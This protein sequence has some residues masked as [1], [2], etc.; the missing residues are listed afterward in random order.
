MEAGLLALE[1]CPADARRADESDHAVDIAG[2][3]QC[4][5]SEED[6]YPTVDYR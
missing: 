1:H 3:I 4:K 6:M 5:G 2:A